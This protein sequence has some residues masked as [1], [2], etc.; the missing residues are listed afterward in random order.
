[1][2][3]AAFAADESPSPTPTPTP[4][5]VRTSEYWLEELGIDDAWETTKGEGVTIAVIDSGIASD[6]DELDGAVAGGADFSGVGSG[7][8]R[9]PLGADAHTRSHGTWV[10]SLAAARGTGEDEGMIGVAPEAKLLAVSIGFGSVSE[11]PFSEQVASAI[12]WSVDQGADVINLSFTTNQ[13]SWDESWDR[14]FQYAFDHDVVIVVAA[15]NRDG[16]TEMIGAPATIPEVLVVG[17]VDQDGKASQG[18]STQGGTIAVSAP[19]EALIGIGPAGDVDSWRGT[20]GSAPIVA[21]I[22][23]LVRAAH[24]ELDA[25][26]VINRIVATT[27][28]APAQ[29]G[30][31]DPIYG[32]GIVDAAAA[33]GDKVPLVDS[34]PVTDVTLKE[35]VRINRGAEEPGETD[36]GPTPTPEPV[37]LPALPPL[38]PP[39][40]AASPY[41]PSPESLREVTLPLM[42]VSAAG[43][44]I[45]LGVVAVSRRFRSNRDSHGSSS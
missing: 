29:E 42:A 24:P 19:S 30:A 12:T 4:D 45:L 20:S 41:L 3:G 11:V 38:D 1:M 13:T 22:A 7:D 16:G 21:G 8:G 27:R 40:E 23:A 15:G 2:P 28:R 26:N 32:F 37:N 17:G 5:P 31:R 33:V 39:A 10:A 14:A 34:S 9:T 43:I 44:L 6:I 36:S 25:D 18:A 35:W